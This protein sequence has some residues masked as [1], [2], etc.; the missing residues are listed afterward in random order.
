MMNYP[1]RLMRG[2]S[3]K[4]FIDDEGRATC[5][6]FQF[7]ICERPDGFDEASIT[8][9]DNQEALGIIMN[10]KRRGK[11]D[12]Q[13]KIGVAILRRCWLDDVISRPNSKNALAYERRPIGDENPYHGNI[14]R[15]S[16]LLP[17]SKQ[18]FAAAIALCVEKIH[19]R[20]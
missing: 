14:L 10:Q 9:Y 3:S 2:V 19:Y 4:D 1:D 20:K 5:A 16:N 17:G 13:F 15:K 8:W 12:F 11:D 7:D 18:L 6:L